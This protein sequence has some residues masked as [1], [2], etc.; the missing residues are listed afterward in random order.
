MAFTVTKTPDEDGNFRIVN[1]TTG[2]LELRTDNN[3]ALDAGG[4]DDRE[5]MVRMAGHITESMDRKN[6]PIGGK[7]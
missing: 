6:R 2:V 1:A 4:S 3:S 5:R 7:T